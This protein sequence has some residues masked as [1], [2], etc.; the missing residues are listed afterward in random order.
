[1]EVLLFTLL[2]IDGSKFPFQKGFIGLFQDLTSF[3][4]KLF[5]LKITITT[6]TTKTVS[7]FFF[8]QC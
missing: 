5:K 3:F 4:E 7:L 6:K 8:K 2:S 1:M